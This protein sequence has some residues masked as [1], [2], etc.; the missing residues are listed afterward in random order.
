MLNET[1]GQ[2][3]VEYSIGL[4]GKEGIDA[5]RAENDGSAVRGWVGILNGIREHEPKPVLYVEK[6]SGNY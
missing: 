1:C 2:V 5:A 3:L 6:T 4:F